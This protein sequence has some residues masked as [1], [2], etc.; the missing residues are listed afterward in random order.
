MD[1]LKGR[2]AHLPYI[3]EMFKRTAVEKGTA[4]SPAEA[5]KHVL[6]LLEKNPSE[7][8]SFAE[9][10]IHSFLN[11]IKDNRSKLG[12]FC[13]SANPQEIKELPPHYQNMLMWSHYAGGFSGFCIEWDYNRLICS[14]NELNNGCR[15]EG[16][17]VRYV[18]EPNLCNF[19]SVDGISDIAM[20]FM[21]SLQF[22]H[23][24]WNYEYEFRFLADRVGK[25]FYD[26]KAV[27]SIYL[28]G[29]IHPKNERELH[30]IMG[31]WQHKPP[32]YKVH[33]AEGQSRFGLQ[34]E[35]LLEGN[36]RSP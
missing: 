13:T 31:E 18:D 5:E 23:R 6:L 3:I 20:S 30:Q 33:I 36:N 27:K 21:R 25:I 2:D 15:V 14:I 12:I 28:G 34:L 9:D 24:Q 17:T 10:T 22:K 11:E 32:V 1:K 35:Q 16:A 4:S 8:Y 19:E 7:F 26:N 29:K